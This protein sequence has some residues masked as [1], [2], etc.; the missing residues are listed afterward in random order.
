[1]TK[2][3]P[4]HATGAIAAVARHCIAT[5]GALSTKKRDS[6]AQGFFEGAARMAAVL[7][8]LNLSADLRQAAD[9]VAEGGFKQV[10]SMVPR[11]RTRKVRVEETEVSTEH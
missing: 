1:M 9:K 2:A 3:N 4:R 8:D 6:S 11:T 10:R 5:S 7:G